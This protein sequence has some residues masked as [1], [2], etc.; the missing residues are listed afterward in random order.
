M[1]KL[2][3]IKGLCQRTARKSAI[4]ASTQFVQLRPFQAVETTRLPNILEIVVLLSE[5]IAYNRNN[6]ICWQ[7]PKKQAS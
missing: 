5:G 2:L 6:K 4:A 3:E 1:P 7:L